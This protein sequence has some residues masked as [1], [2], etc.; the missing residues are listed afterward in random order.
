MKLKLL[1][2]GIAISVMLYSCNSSPKKPAYNRKAEEKKLEKAISEDVRSITHTSINAISMGMGS[3]VMNSVMSEGEQDSLLMK[4]FMP[5]LKEEMALLADAELKKV[6]K[7]QSARYTFIGK[8]MVK[9]KD[10]LVEG[11]KKTYSFAAPFV[12]VAIDQAV[13]LSE[14][15]Q[16]SQQN[17]ES[18]DSMSAS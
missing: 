2:A 17:S 15:V 9:H 13:K 14:E 5:I 3:V 10:P 11:L 18:T 4:P 12:E 8:I 6:N 7:E 16:K 1:Y